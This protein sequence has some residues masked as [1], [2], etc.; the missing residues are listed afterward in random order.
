MKNKQTNEQ[1]NKIVLQQVK[2]NISTVKQQDRN[3][4]RLQD[5]KTPKQHDIKT[6]RQ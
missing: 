2:K 1:D 6:A 4:T 5:N 3:I